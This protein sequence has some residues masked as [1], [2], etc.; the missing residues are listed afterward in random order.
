MLKERDFVL[1]DPR[2]NSLKAQQI[3]KRNAGNR[4]REEKFDKGDVVFLK[5]QPYR[6]R[7]FSQKI[8]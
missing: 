2:L 5:L 8:M 3:M 7:S 1:D 4:R 6:Q